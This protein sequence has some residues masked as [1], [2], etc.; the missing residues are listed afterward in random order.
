LTRPAHEQTDTWYAWA[1]R[2][3]RDTW[4]RLASGCTEAEALNRAMDMHLGCDWCILPAGREPT[5][6]RRET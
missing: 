4:K 5:E 2:D 6:N 3:R 1:R